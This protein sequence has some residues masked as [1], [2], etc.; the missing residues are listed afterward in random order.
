MRTAPAPNLP[1]I[2]GMNPGQIVAAGGGGGGGGDGDG[3]DGN[4]KEG[5]GGGSGGDDATSDNRSAPDPAKYPTCGTE[6]HPV[7][8]V[9]GRVFTHPITDLS[10]PGPLPLTFERA[11]S[12]A[13]S[14]EDQGLG[15]GWAHSLGWFVQV[16]RRRIRVWNDRGVSVDF[17]VPQVGDTELGDWGWVLRRELWGFAV[18]SNDGVW[19]IF[20]VSHD[21]GKTFRLSAV[22]DRNKNRI[23]ITYDDGKL[24]EIKDSAGRVVKVT[25]TKDGRI[26]ALQVKNSE[27]QG[28]W[29]AFARYQYDDK[30]RLVRVT[31]ADDHSWTYE[32]DEFNRLLRDTDRSGLS[33]C[34]RYDEKDRGIEAWGE[35]RGKKDPSL[36]DDVPTFLWDGRT[37]AKGIYHRKFDYHARGF[38]EV[39]DTTETRRYFGNGKGTLDKAVSGGAV[40]SSVYDDR[41]FEIEKTDPL[42]A[43]TRWVRDER[44]RI[45][46]KIDPL[47][48]HTR[49]TRDMYGL[50]IQLVDPAG[51]VTVVRR[52]Q[53]GNPE[54]LQDAAG[55]VTLFTHEERGLVTSV[56]D[57]V[58]AVTRY[59]YDAHGNLVSVGQANGANWQIA[60]DGLGR[61]TSVRDPLG[62]ETRYAHSAR[63]DLVAVYDAAGGVTRYAYDGERHVQQVTSPKGGATHLTWGGFHKLCARRDANGRVV[64]LAYSREGELVEV[65][66]EREAVHRLSYDIAGRLVDETTFDGRRLRYRLDPA[67]RVVRLTNGAGEATTIVYDLAGQIVARELP[68]ESQET[69]EYNAR[70]ELVRARNAAGEFALE[71]DPVGRVVR[72]LQTVD[73]SRQWVDIAHDP[74]GNR[75]R[76]TTSLGHTEAIERDVMG[77][78]VATLLDGGFRIQ[79]ATD[80]LAREVARTLPG[81]GVIEST[82]DPLGRLAQRRVRGSVAAHGVGADEPEWLGTRDDGVTASSSYQYDA[83][84]E[85]E[86]AHDLA[87][88]ATRYQYDPIGQLLA[89]IPEKARTEVFRYDP[90]GNVYEA[91]AG[92]PARDYD[93]GNRLVRRGST[94]YEWDGDGRLTR[95]IEHTG[96]GERI[97]TYAWNGAGLL[98][99]VGAPDGR[100]MQFAY[101]PFARRVRKTVSVREG[102]ERRIVEET[103]IVWD[104]H[105]IAHEL[106]HSAGRANLDERTYCFADGSFVPVAQRRAERPVATS[107]TAKQDDVGT[108]VPWFSYVNDPAG[109]P[110]RLVDARGEVACELDRSAWGL[111]PIAKTTTTPLRFQGQYE[112]DETGFYY[113]RARYYS[114]EI[115]RF[116]SADPIDIAGGLNVFA[117]ARNPILWVDPC[118][119]AD[120]VSTAPNTAYFWSGRT[121]GVSSGSVVQG[122]AGANGGTSLEMLLDKRGITM[123]PWD[124]HN[125]ASVAKWKEVSEN[126]ARGC[127]GEVKAVVGQ[128]MRPGNVW[129]TKE[130]PALKANPNVTKITQ[131]DPSTRAETVIYTR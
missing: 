17:R 105:T 25:T 75:V 76:R 4:D 53:R 98:A 14:K 129:E 34:F 93:D 74:A 30:G 119:L 54:L 120:D 81:G 106:R 45:L 103:R 63:G 88:G 84:G 39:T 69:F 21:E 102:L 96:G 122:I 27:H 62:A 131:I 124:E 56:T 16:E 1:P 85:L 77:A 8:V 3:S 113:N 13:A 127:S 72:E 37:R 68:D 28:Q 91:A 5:A 20:S 7:D 2:P 19:R 61:R 95:K 112:D 42:G 78:R 31:D 47:G 15:F 116:I 10:L 121:N 52:D 44:G 110:Q 60:Y 82:F 64:R 73:G 94:A 29:V 92:D 114:P 70:G 123:P 100:T 87:R 89:S 40:T 35:Y 80:A 22:D 107:T 33:F 9:T 48:R 51:G 97:W 32:Y 99:A 108:A 79:H 18:D 118:G 125:P 50:P 65:H 58:G 55:G 43:T 23:G 83:D 49:L 86:V 126:Y 59:D 41:G 38:T 57:P 130:L 6:S 109:T 66:N 46:E 67:G 117:Y 36:A 11:Y 128:D 12:A 115:G 111:T 26:A 101:D 104:A 90:A 71:R 24:A